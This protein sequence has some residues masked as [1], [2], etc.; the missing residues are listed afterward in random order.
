MKFHRLISYLFFPG[1]MALIGFATIM[2]TITFPFMDDQRV[3]LHFWL[4]AVSAYVLFPLLILALFIRIGWLPDIHLYDRQKRNISYPV[5]IAGC[6]GAKL[7]L[8]YNPDLNRLLYSVYMV[9]WHDAVIIILTL[10]WII[11]ALGLKASA[12][13]A[14]TS[15]FA[16]L[17]L[18]LALHENAW[19]S[20]IV[21]LI[22]YT[23]V[24][25]SR[26]ALSAHSHIE[27]VA[28]SLTGFLVTFALIHFLLQ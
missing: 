4:V 15:G 17:C 10:I 1:N 23:L 7:Y 28:G 12:H 14:G 18:Y 25:L 19:L 3:F 24:Y 5:A 26:R 6:I 21:S 8:T 27:L 16:G 20:L 9:H 11:N 22:L 2:V 13:A